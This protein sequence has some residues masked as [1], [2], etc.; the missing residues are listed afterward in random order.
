M[1]RRPGL[2]RGA[3]PREQGTPP[4]GLRALKQQRTR[5]AIQ[6]AGLRLFAE[7]GYERTTCEQI[8]VAAEISPATFYR[9]F[10]TKEDVVL[11]DDYDQLL[12]TLTRSRPAD[13]APIR[14]VRRALA[15]A[16][17]TLDDSDLQTVRERLQLVLSAPALRARRSEQTRATEAVLAHELAPRMGAAPADIEVR[18]V[19]AAIV[20]G[21]VVG[22]EHWAQAGGSLAAHIDQALGALEERLTRVGRPRR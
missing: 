8:A 12:V 9:Y 1:T 13:E 17:G 3:A 18:A 2:D 7:Q 10:P 16:L 20:A 19:A 5:A 6:A 11:V 21:L 4:S 15:A 14:A 22:V